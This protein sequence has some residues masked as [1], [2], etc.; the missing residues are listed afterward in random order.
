MNKYVHYDLTRAWV[1]Q[2]GFSEDEAEVVAQSDLAVDREHKWRGL[3]NAK[4]HISS[5]F[6]HQLFAEACAE[7]SLEK[8]GQSLHV[9]Q[10]FCTHRYGLKRVLGIPVL[11]PRRHFD[12]WTDPD[13]PEEIKTS[14][15]QRT[16]ELLREYLCATHESP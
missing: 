2:A 15:E 4:W 16:R 1:L 10:D 14:I 9:M 5:D 3:R 7:H 11:D 12:V 8:F 6:S 13:I